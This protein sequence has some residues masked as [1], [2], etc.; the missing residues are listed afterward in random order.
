MSIRQIE[1]L[2][3][4]FAVI[5]L[6]APGFEASDDPPP[7]LTTANYGATVMPTSHGVT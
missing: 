1:D 4:E 2:S 5:V 7:T 3:D 6:D